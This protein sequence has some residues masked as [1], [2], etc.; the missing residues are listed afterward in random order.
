MESIT[1]TSNN[2]NEVTNHMGG[3]SFEAITPIINLSLIACSFFLGEPTYYNEEIDNKDVHPNISNNNNNNEKMSQQYLILNYDNKSRNKIFLDACNNALNYDFSKVLEFAVKCRTEYYMRKSPA[4]ILA[5][6]ALHPNRQEFNKKNP[7]I[8]R[9]AVKNCCNIPSDMTSIHQ[10]WMSLTNS[11]PSDKRP[12]YPSF[13]KRS[14]EDKL[15]STTS[16]QL[17]KYRKDNINMARICHPNKKSLQINSNLNGG[18]NRGLG[19]LMTDGKLKLEDNQKKWDSLRSQGLSWIEILERLEWKMPHMAALRNVRNFAFSDPGIENMNKYL[20]MLLA[21]VEG[22]KQFPFQYIT[23][24]KNFK[25]YSN[26]VNPNKPKYSK[27]KKSKQFVPQ[28]KE[29][30]SIY[31][32]IIISCFEECLQKSM[33]SFPSLTGDVISLSDNSG[34]A[35]GTFTSKYGTVKV[36]DIDNLS[37]LFTAYN[38]TGKGVVGIFGDDFHPYIVDKNRPLLDQYD[39]IIEIGKTIG[40]GTENGV[41]LFFKNAF[42]DPTMYKF[43][44]WFCYSDMQVGHG[45]LYGNDP[46]I[47]NEFHFQKDGSNNRSFT[48]YINIHECLNKYRKEINSKIN[49]FMVQTAGYNNTILPELLYRGSILSGWTGNEILYAKIYSE[50]WDQIDA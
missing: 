26:N 25:S 28:I 16:Y 27:G 34:S 49:T 48:K 24:Y 12:G 4:Q 15:K 1:T 40:Q 50:L 17:E 9:N 46:D 18:E 30:K 23:A 42:N 5:I 7:M 37:A 36:S 32:D 45:E 8:F 11:I 47:E 21:G 10:A 3:T 13:L 44:Y 19:Q 33:K 22:G 38:C 2:N 14:C 29:I 41:W 31:Q 35:H 39:E 43:D 6:A 20:E